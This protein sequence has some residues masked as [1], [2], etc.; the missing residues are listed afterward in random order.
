MAGD[1]SRDGLIKIPIA[2]QHVWDPEIR[3]VGQLSERIP[4]DPAANGELHD[5]APSHLLTERPNDETTLLGPH[6]S[7]GDLRRLTAAVVAALMATTTAACDKLLDV[8]NPASVPIEALDDP[9]LMQTL[10]AAAI[11]QFQCAFANF[12]ANAGIL[13]GEYWVSSNF[14]NS[15]PWEWRGVVQIKGT[16]GSC[17]NRN[18]TSLGFYT[19]MQQAR[20]QLDDLFERAS[21]FTDQEVPNRQRMLAEAR[22]YPALRPHHSR[23]DDVRDGARRRPEDDEPGSVGSRRGAVHGSDHVATALGLDRETHLA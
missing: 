12:A 2:D 10:E 23:R 3:A 8:E 17:P 14:V 4:D 15:H 6:A 1:T 22:A 11:Q 5:H 16:G 18:A 21:A 7:D 9:A 19:P 20:F 13:S